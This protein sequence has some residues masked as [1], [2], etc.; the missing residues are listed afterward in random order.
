MHAKADLAKII[1]TLSPPGC[2]SSGL[3]RWQK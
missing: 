3:N 1:E 2:F